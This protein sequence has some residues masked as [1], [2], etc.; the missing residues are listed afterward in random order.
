M[1]QISGTL[2][3]KHWKSILFFAAAA[4][5]ISELAI[6]LSFG[7]SFF[8]LSFGEFA[9]QLHVDSRCVFVLAGGGGGGVLSAVLMQNEGSL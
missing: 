4:V 9:E 8:G 7:M 3:D 2:L 5:S 1:V 6:P